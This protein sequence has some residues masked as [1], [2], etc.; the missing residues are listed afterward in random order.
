MKK[1]LLILAAIA[2]VCAFSACDKEGVY[3]PKKKIVKIYEQQGGQ[4]KELTERWTWD[5]RNLSKISNGTDSYYRKFTY[6]KNR[7][8]KITWSDGEF[9][10]FSFD[11]N[12]IKKVEYHGAAG[13]LYATYNFTH[14][15]KKVTT[16]TIEEYDYDIT[17]K[18]KKD[19]AATLRLFLPEQTAE[20]IVTKKRPASL[21]KGET[22][23]TIYEYEWDGDNIQTMTVSEISENYSY[24]R[25]VTYTYDKK[26]NPYYNFFESYAT[27]KNNVTL[28]EGVYVETNTGNTVSYT[29]TYEYDITYDGNWPTE[30]LSMYRNGSYTSLYTTYYVYED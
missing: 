9:F 30:I 23:T 10:V 17:A 13:E 19:M 25:E 5:G 6:D 11:G 8:K 22:T 15:K 1:S 28:A 21:A 14:T 18:N 4:S 24:T 2:I 12:F 29:Y 26:T 7:I 3:H 27:S 20:D 16:L